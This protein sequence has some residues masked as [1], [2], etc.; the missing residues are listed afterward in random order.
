MSFA[1]I[2]K[3]ATEAPEETTVIGRPGRGRGQCGG[4]IK[5]VIICVRLGIDI[6]IYMYI[7]FLML[8]TVGQFLLCLCVSF[9]FILDDLLAQ[10]SITVCMY[11]QGPLSNIQT[12]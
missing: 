2:K 5:V 1:D 10:T 9:M 11:A 3:A 8:L 6:T 7:I 4:K 12:C